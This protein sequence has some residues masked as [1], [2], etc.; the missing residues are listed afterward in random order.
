MLEIQ[1]VADGFKIVRAAN[2]VTRKAVEIT[3]L[4][5]GVQEPALS[6]F[7]A[8]GLGNQLLQV[9]KLISLRN[10]LGIRRQIFF[11]SLGGF[12]THNNQVNAADAAL[13]THAGLL[14]QAGDAIKAFYDATVALGIE[15]AVTTFTMSDFSRTGK[16]NGSTGS[17]HA[18]GSHQIVVGGAVRGGDLYGERGPNGTVFPTLAPGGPDDTDSGANARGRWI[19]TTSVDQFGAT[20]AVWFG[21]PAA[22]LPGVFPNL[23]NFGA[24]TNLGFMT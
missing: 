21:V 3:A 7:P 10:V 23:P 9:A 14:T 16:A 17:D 1:G 13:G 2:S 5:R 24:A 8:T 12:D 18:W 11:C 4:L 22:D 15:G 6:G 20:L 19:P